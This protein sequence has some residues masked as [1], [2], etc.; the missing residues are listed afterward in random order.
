MNVKYNRNITQSASI[1][2]PTLH[3]NIDSSWTS[4]SRGPEDDLIKVETCRPDNILFL[5]YIKCSVV[6][7]T[8]TLYLYVITLR[9]GKH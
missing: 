6:L 7:L 8:D 1:W 9:D 4:F 5:L 2:D 3:C